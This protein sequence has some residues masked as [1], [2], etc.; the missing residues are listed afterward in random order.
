M[1]VFY[2]HVVDGP[3][4][5]SVPSLSS[6]LKKKKS[7]VV[8]YPSFFGSITMAK[9]WRSLATEKNSFSLGFTE[10]EHRAEILH[11]VREKYKVILKK[12]RRIKG[13]DSVTN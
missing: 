10:R 2:I 3:Q 5:K 1:F 6:I 8:I 9:L 13:R 4:N 7:I 11:D 12:R